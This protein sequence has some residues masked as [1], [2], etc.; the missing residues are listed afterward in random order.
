ME[1]LNS[2]PNQPD[3]AQLSRVADILTLSGT[4][5]AAFGI[6]SIIKGL[7]Y[8][9]TNPG[10]FEGLDNPD[11][12]RI[13]FSIFLIISL[14]L[15]VY[16]ARCARKESAALLDPSDNK[17]PRILYLIIAGIITFGY[18]ASLPLEIY[19]FVQSDAGLFD[20]VPSIIVELTCIY[21]AFQLFSS[22][23]HTLRYRKLRE[24]QHAN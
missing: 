7:I 1:T 21:M 6:W 3:A 18:F 4:G 2:K 22:A 16:V 20:I 8:Y 14:A 12:L 9:W 10:Y 13:F 11:L 17:K 5:F 19:S 15:R 23:I 24:Q